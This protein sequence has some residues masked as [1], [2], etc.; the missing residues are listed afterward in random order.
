MIM[1]CLVCAG[2]T[3]GRLQTTKSWVRIRTERR[4]GFLLQNPQTGSGAQSA[5]YSM[6]TALLSTK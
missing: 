2:G 1:N 3:A 4:S 6:G 5:S